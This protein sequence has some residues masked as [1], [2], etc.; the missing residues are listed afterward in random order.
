MVTHVWTR[1]ECV[2][3]EIRDERRAYGAA[4]ENVAGLEE[5][6]TFGDELDGQI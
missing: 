2:E 6:E 3:C 5:A 1:G 4:G